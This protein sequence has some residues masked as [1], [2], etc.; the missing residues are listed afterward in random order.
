MKRFAGMC[1]LGAFCVALTT[2]AMAVEISM[3]ISGP[4]AVNETT[5][6]AGQ[7]VSFDVYMAN[8]SSWKG[9]SIGFQVKSPTIKKVLH[10][11]DSGKGINA[12][13]DVKGYNGFQDK[14]IWD[15]SGVFVVDTLWNG[16]LPDTLGFGG[17][18]VK[19][20][21]LPHPLQKNLSFD[22]IFP[23]AGI[24]VVD[25]SFY[26]PGGQ[27]LFALPE[28]HPTWKGPYKFTVVK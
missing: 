23:E 6:K 17:I 24:V 18:C 1:A 7:K 13:G 11:A 26:P 20:S 12:R 2:S 21:Y 4:G 28:H 5:I 15:L 14:S 8:D 25:S 3:K 19:A 16:T 22:L 9:F 27:W 10:P